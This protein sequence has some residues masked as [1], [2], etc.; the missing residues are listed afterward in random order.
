M[1][2]LR[3]ANKIFAVLSS[4][5]ML[6]QPILPVFQYLTPQVFAQEATPT[7]TPVPTPDPTITTTPDATP[8]ATPTEEVTP[9]PTETVTPTPTIDVTPTATPDATPTATPT[10]EVTPVPTD[11]TTSP[12]TT[13]TEP[14]KETG[15]PSGEASPPSD[16]GQILDGASVTATPEPTV[17]PEPTEDG[18]LQA[19]VLQNVEANSLNLD[20]I[21]PSNSASLTTDKADYAPTDTAIITG[22]G[23]KPNHDYNITVSS[24]DEPA[25]STTDTITTDA[26]GA[27]VYAYQLD[28]I[29]RPNYKVEVTNQGGHIIADTKFTDS[30]T[31]GVDEYSQCS[32]DDGDGYTTGN[33]GC[34]WVNGNLQHSNST[35]YESD[36]T[37]QLL[38]IQD[39]PTGDHTVTIKY[40]TTKGGKH[41]YDFITDDTFSESWITS[42]DICDSS[43]VHLAGCSG[44]IPDISS[45][46]PTDANAA[47][48]DAVHSNRHFKIRNGTWVS[49]GI[50]S[51]PTLASGSYAG[52]SETSIQL[53]FH[54]DASSCTN[55]YTSGGDPVCEVVITWGAHVSDQHDWG[56]GT[57]AVSIPGSP[58]HVSLVEFDG[59]SIGS[60]DNQMQADAIIPFSTITIHKVT[61]PTGGTGFGYTTTGG[62]TP[63]TFSLNDAGTQSYTT[64]VPG[65]YTIS[66]DDPSGNGYS[67][68]GLTCNTVTGTG[69]SATPNVG[70]RTVSITIGTAGGGNVDCTFTNTQQNGHLTVQKT[71]IPAGSQ[72]SFTINATGTG[73][74][75]GG[76]AGS[77]SDSTDQ[78]YEVTTGTYSV[79]ET[80]PTG[81]TE[82]SNTCTGV[83]VAAGGTSYCTITNTQKGHIIVNKVTSGADDTFAFT[84]SGTG[85]SGFSLSNGQFNDQEVVPG[86]YTVSETALS[87]W[88]SDGGACDNGETPGSLDVGAGETVTCTFTNTKLR[89]ITAC[90]YDDHNGNGAKEESES[91]LDGWDMTLTPGNVTQATVNGCTTFTNLSPGDYSVAETLKTDWSNTTPLSQNVTLISSQNETVY[92]GN[93]ACATISG[94]KWEDL[95]GDGVKDAGEPTLP[96]WTI[97]LNGTVA[98]DV[99]DANGEYSFKVCQAGTYT[100]SETIPDTKVW[101]QTSPGGT[102]PNHQVD[103]TSGGTYTG[104]DFGNAKYAKI[105]GVKYRDNDGDGTLDTNDLTATLS[106]WVFDLYDGTTNAVLGTYTT[107]SDGYYEFTGLL[108]NKTY[109]VLEQLKPG[110]TQTIGPTPTPTPFTV[111]S[112]ETKEINFANFENMSVTVCKVE[113]ADG[114]LTSTTDRTPVSGWQIDL[115]KNGQMY[116][117]A[118]VTER[119]GCYTWTNLTPG[120]YSTQEESQ[121]GW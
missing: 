53:K 22:A 77:I 69:T 75:T 103:V 70:T 68:T 117:N 99:T 84:T 108:V 98:T 8:T 38:A 30:A 25:T 106:G 17:T 55:A 47:G 10:E 90:K 52:D 87:G 105:Y 51:G 1:K 57:S 28:G 9:V 107:L 93:F 40:G 63:S 109:Y 79:T 121:T 34:R 85:Y 31:P 86:S 24:T 81:W 72:Q 65:S 21:D 6:V 19:V 12:A 13:S 16:Q 61:N 18:Q 35:Y 59:G 71:T 23:F 112:G 115:L 2:T 95:N 101:Y 3:W 66:E 7:V 54:V 102:S 60:R 26:D 64:V 80:V 33:T 39:L 56:A 27:F 5:L 49:G 76:G 20:N 14:P 36:A 104:K 88:S 82:T 37:P 118:Q 42:A 110:W 29:Y 74:I 48:H 15:P 119:D 111:Q 43:L 32:N 11:Q 94:V 113:D 41:A 44:L 50:L 58:Y 114:S 91:L 92:F 116:D 120:S 45:L 67:L 83:V 46:I 89:N 96:D 78:N 97:N 100:I 4:I 73:T 62:L